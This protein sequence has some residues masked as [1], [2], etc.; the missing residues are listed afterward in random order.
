VAGILTPNGAIEANLLCDDF[1]KAKVAASPWALTLAN[2]A[3]LTLDTANFISGGQ[4][5]KFLSGTSASSEIH[6]YLSW[7]PGAKELG[8]EWT[9]SVM[10]EN[11]S[12]L[13]LYCSFRD[14][15]NWNRAK[16][17]HVYSTNVWSYQDSAGVQQPLLTRDTS[18]NTAVARWHRVLMAINLQSLTWRYCTVDDQD[19]SP[20][21]SGLQL[22]S[23]AD[24][25]APLM[26]DLAAEYTNTATPGTTYFDSIRAYLR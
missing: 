8:V 7:T 18:E 11:P 25:T 13:A 6:R 4:S 14:A 16:L 5:M 3:T 20:A 23:S 22:R 1:D 2:A 26:I 19:F 24:A 21:V 9:F 12:N 17:L 10:D 15:T